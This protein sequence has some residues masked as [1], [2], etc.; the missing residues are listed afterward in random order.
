MLKKVWLIIGGLALIAG[1]ISSAFSVCQE[2]N[3]WYKNLKIGIAWYKKDQKGDIFL[4][5]TNNIEVTLNESDLFAS[6]IRMPINLAIKNKNDEPLE[7][8]KVELTYDKSLDIRSEA[9][10]KVP[11]EPGKL[12]F[13][14]NFG[15]LSV[16]KNYTPLPTIDVLSFPTFFAVEE[17]LVVLSDGV[18]AY[19]ATIIGLHVNEKKDI[20]FQK[21]LI[22]VFRSMPKTI[23]LS[24]KI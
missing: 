3:G 12:V 8:V 15:L 6:R 16:S 4:V 23:H 18:P 24:M 19:T 14:H 10:Q 20:L 1:L 7:I 21:K 22:L 11:I 13:E 2:I 17:I 5:D 9:E